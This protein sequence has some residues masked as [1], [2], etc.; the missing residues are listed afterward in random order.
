MMVLTKYDIY[1]RVVKGKGYNN[2]YYYIYQIQI[3]AKHL[4]IIIHYLERKKSMLLL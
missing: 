4:T 2:Q 3:P 1:H